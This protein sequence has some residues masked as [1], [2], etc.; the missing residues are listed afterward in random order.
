[1]LTLKQPVD[2]GQGKL[3]LE[4]GATYFE[5]APDHGARITALKHAGVEHLTQSGGANYADAV[6]STFW[7]SPQTW[8]WPPPA[9]I[10]NG[11]Y[12]AVIADTGSIT[13]DGESNPQTSLKVTK[14]FSADLQ[15]DRLLL[16]YA[17]TNTG[18]EPV[19]WAP[20][21]I[22]RMPATGL[23]FWPTGSEP[24]GLQPLANQAAQGH[25]WCDP[26]KTE[27]EGKLFADGAG[28]Y[29]GYLL[30]DRLLLKQFQDQPASAVAPG[31]A[32]IELYV[33][34]DHD[35]VEVENQGAL[36][37]IAPGHTVRWQVTW[38]VRKL[39]ANVVPSLGNPDLIAFVA[40][41]LK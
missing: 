9:E 23:A 15:R 36:A 12:S 28:G 25:S 38:Y 20:W 4:F 27:G 31:E 14:T 8:P 34:P 41:T 32:E 1:M 17:M 7:P 37:R 2:R 11:K 5:I 40:Q 24:W 21:E 18:T 6:G 10:D 39:P 35:Y 29:L 22:T 30:G 16:E 33:N 19:E 13:L 26:S 3:V